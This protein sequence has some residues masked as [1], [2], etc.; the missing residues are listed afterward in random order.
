MK[1]NTLIL[2][3]CT[4]ISFMGF[5]QP[6]FS[7]R[8]VFDD[9][10]TE[11]EFSD[12]VTGKGIYWWGGTGSSTVSRNSANN[13]L[14]VEATQ[15]VYEYTPFGVSFGDDNGDLPGGVPYTIDIS[16]NGKW[17]F[18]ITNYGTED[19]H[20][21][22]ACQDIED[23]IVDTNPVPNSGGTI[24]FDNLRV[25]AYQV[26]LLV[27]AGETVSFKANS[28][29]DAGGGKL[30]NCDF[31]QMVWGDYGI[32]DAKT[33]THIGAGVRK[34]C[35]LT[36]IKSI[37]IT[38]LNAAKNSVDYHNLALR[39]G[40]FGISNFKVGDLSLG[41]EDELENNKILVYPNPSKGELTIRNSSSEE[42]S[43]VKIINGLGQI[44]YLSTS[45]SPN[46]ELFIDTHSFK[47]GVYFAKI[48]EVI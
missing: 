31:T 35:D 34:R 8:S 3:I 43:S 12:P 23:T 21:R 48:G 22:V 41:F 40:K 16:E 17:S 9:F 27:P 33:K 30:N 1:K 24:A 39:N 44:V 19:L 36:K 29:N 47:S 38:P 10:S 6:A 14:L 28:P 20:I 15:G 25:W 11:D 46:N 5:S 7:D 18:D 2:L 37:M 26:Q 4:S 13:E 42:I 32:W 45:L